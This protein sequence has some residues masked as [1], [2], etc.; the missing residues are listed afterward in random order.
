I[1]EM[2]ANNL[3]QNGFAEQNFVHSA[4]LRERTSA[5]AIGGGVAIPHAE[6]DF[7]KESVVSLAVLRNPIQWGSEMVSVV[8][9]QA[10]AKDDQEMTKSLMQTIASISQNPA[11]VEKLNEAGSIPDILTVFEQ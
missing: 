9:L 1:V 8:F 10:I 4:M 6:P 3:A 7:V 2:L 11:I 5:A